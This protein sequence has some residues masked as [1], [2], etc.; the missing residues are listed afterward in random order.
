MKH[1]PADF[2]QQPDRATGPAGKRDL[3]I[4]AAAEIF[5]E[6]GYATASI[7]GIASRAGV[8][9]QTVYNQFG[10][11]EKVF[12]EVVGEITQRSSAGFFSVLD[13]FP[14][15]PADLEAE[16]TAFTVRMLKT[17]ACNPHSR[18]LTRLIEREGQRYPAL[19]ATWRE[20]GPGKKYPA[21]A[22]RFA[23]LAHAGHLQI[24]D[25]SLAARQYMALCM[26]DIR[27]DM[28]LG[29]QPADAE[30]ELMAANAVKTFLRAFSAR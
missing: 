25:P 1:S 29:I 23:Q 7:D 24:D 14:D 26:A 27:S 15:N 17:A 28:Q 13:T 4:E 20:Y 18:W 12:K 11:K 30:I 9:R 6:V 21:V 19:F 22:A 16:L 3:I 2:R 8:S 10:D 5:A